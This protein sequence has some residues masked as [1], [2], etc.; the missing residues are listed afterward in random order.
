MSLPGS[1]LSYLYIRPVY[2]NL[3]GFIAD[4][5]DAALLAVLRYK[6]ASLAPLSH[7]GVLKR[8]VKLALAGAPPLL[9][10]SR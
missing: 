6:P 4:G 8:S 2:M 7:L 5:L 10:L 9:A 3:A 1:S